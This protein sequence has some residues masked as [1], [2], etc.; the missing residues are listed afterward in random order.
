LNRSDQ[1]PRPL[2]DSP[3]NEVGRRKD[4]NRRGPLTER[5][6]RSEVA[7]ELALPIPFDRRGPEQDGT[8]PWGGVIGAVQIQCVPASVARFPG[9]FGPTSGSQSD[10]QRIVPI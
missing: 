5:A 10:A 2:T 3:A 6:G 1:S 7:Y 8:R 9:L 4:Q